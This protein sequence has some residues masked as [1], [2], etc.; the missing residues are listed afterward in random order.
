MGKNCYFATQQIDGVIA[1]ELNCTAREVANL[2]SLLDDY[3]EEAK[4]KPFL[5][6]YEDKDVPAEVLSDLAQTLKAFKQVL[7][8]KAE[9]AISYASTHL[10]STFTATAVAL[11]SAKQFDLADTIAWQ[12]SKVVHALS[13]KT[14]YSIEE[15]C[16]GVTDKSGNPMFGERQIFRKIYKDILA[17]YQKADPESDTYQ[18]L[19]NILNHWGALCMH[20]RCII[21]DT[22]RI[23]LGVYK[24]YAKDINSEEMTEELDDMFNNG[25][26]DPETVTKESWQEEKDKISSF[27]RLSDK[28]KSV[29]S[30]FVYL[31]YEMGVVKTKEGLP[32][33]VVNRVDIK[34]GALGHPSRI[35]VQDTH[36]IIET[37]VRRCPDSKTMFKV[38]EDSAKG[39]IANYSDP[40]HQNSLTLQDWV[41]YQLYAY[42]TG[43][44]ELSLGVAPASPNPQFKTSLFSNYHTGFTLHTGLSRLKSKI[45][46]F[47]GYFYHRVN[48]NAG[49]STAEA[50]L[51]YAIR[52]SYSSILFDQNGKMNPKCFQADTEESKFILSILSDFKYK[53][54][55]SIDDHSILTSGTTYFSSVIYKGLGFDVTYTPTAEEI[56]YAYTQ[57]YNALN[58]I[59]IKDISVSTIVKLHKSNLLTKKMLGAIYDI[60]SSLQS[61]TNILTA[62]KSTSE[63][64]KSKLGRNILSLADMV[65]DAMTSLVYEARARVTDKNGNKTTVSSN[66]APCF[67]TDTVDPLIYYYNA[68]QITEA[69]KFLFDKY[70]YSE[71]FYTGTATSREE[72]NNIQAEDI[73]NYWLRHVWECLEGKNNFLATFSHSRLA[74]MQVNKEDIRM[75]NLFEKDVTIALAQLFWQQVDK[76]D[77]AMATYPLFILGDSGVFRIMDGPVFDT[78]D[79]PAMWTQAINNEIKILGMYAGANEFLESHGYEK[80]HGT[81][82]LWQTSVIAPFLRA[83]EASSEFQ[84]RPNKDTTLLEWTSSALYRS[85]F[86][87]KYIIPVLDEQVKSFKESFDNL[88]LSEMINVE[89]KGTTK[90]AFSHIDSIS[91]VV[92]SDPDAKATL[93]A[94]L[95]KKIRSFVYNYGLHMADQMHMMTVST[96]LYKSLEELQKRYKEVHASGSALDIYAIDPTTKRP[97]F[98]TVNEKGETVLSPYETALYFKDI[99]TNIEE[100][101]PEFAEVVH[102]VLEDSPGQY[103]KYLKNSLTDGQSFRSLES[104]R[105]ISIAQDIWSD[106]E[107]QFYQLLSK[108][109]K[110]PGYNGVLTKEQMKQLDDIGV[111]FQP[112]KPYLFCH[113]MFSYTDAK[114]NQ[115]SVPIAVQ[116]K[117]AEIILIPEFLAEGSNLRHLATAMTKKGIDIA[118]STEVVKVGCFGECDIAFKTGTNKLY[119]DSNGVT[120]GNATTREEQMELED[121]AEQRVAISTLEDMEIALGNAYLHKLDLTTY[122]RQSNVPLHINNPNSI[123]TQMYKIFFTAI[124]MEEDAD[125]SGYLPEG[126]TEIAVGNGHTISLDPSTKHSGQN[127]C[128][129]YNMLIAAS[130]IQGFEEL[131][132]DMQSHEDLSKILSQMSINSSRDTVYNLMNYA[133]ALE[134]EE[135]EE[136]AAEAFLVPLFDSSI[137]KETQANLISLFRKKVNKLMMLGG[138]AVQ[139]SAF[140]IT[141]KVEDSRNPDDGGLKF[142]CEYVKDRAGNFV[143]DEKGKKIKNVLYA[144]CELPWDLFYTDM[145]GNRVELDYDEYC[146]ED[147]S[148]KL[149]ENGKIKLDVDFPGMR[150]LVAY[151]I[152]TERAYSALNLKVVR[153]SRK[154]NGGVIKVPS[155]GTTIAGFDFDIDKLY[156]LRKEFVYQKRKMSDEEVEQVWEALFEEHGDIAMA[157]EIERLK[158]RGQKF[159]HKGKEVIIDEELPRNQLRGFIK[160]TDFGFDEKTTLQDLFN[161]KAIELGLSTKLK[162][163]DY[164][165]SALQNSKVAR[166]NELL[167]LTQLRLRDVETLDARLTPGGFDGA[168]GASKQHRIL[169]SKEALGKL[170]GLSDTE[171]MSTLSELADDKSKDYKSSTDLINPITFIQYNQQNQVAGK[172]IGVFAN[173]NNNHIYSAMLKGLELPEGLSISFGSMA[174]K[175]VSSLLAYNKKSRNKIDIAVAEFLAASVDA[176][177]DPVLNDLNLNSVTA[178]AGAVLARLGYSALE[179]GALFNQPIIKEI[180]AV[181]FNDHIS[182]IDTAI[183]IACENLFTSEMPAMAKEDLTTAN[184]LKSIASYN[185]V[186]KEQGAISWIKSSNV[187]LMQQKAIVEL[188]KDALKAG[189]AVGV[190][191]RSTKYTAASSVPSSLGHMHNMF[192]QTQ[193]YEE[194]NPSEKVKITGWDGESIQAMSP[195]ASKEAAACFSKGSF[196]SYLYEISHSPFAF[197]QCMYDMMGLFVTKICAKHFPYETSAYKRTRDLMNQMTKSTTLSGETVNSIHEEFTLYTLSKLEGSIFNGNTVIDKTDAE[198]NPITISAHE[199]YT[200]IVPKKVA[201]WQRTFNAKANDE[202]FE[203]L[204]AGYIKEVE[205]I[206][207]Y[208]HLLHKLQ[209]LEYENEEGEI[210]TYISLNNAFSNNTVDKMRMMQAWTQLALTSEDAE[211]AVDLFMYC[212]Y[213]TGLAPSP[214][215]FIH[216]ATPFVK[217]LVP[218]DDSRNFLQFERDLLD[219]HKAIGTTA[220]INNFINLYIRNNSDDWQFVYAPRSRKEIGVFNSLTTEIREDGT[221]VVKDEIE[222]NLD[223]NTSNITS[224]FSRII[225]EIQ[226][227][228]IGSPEIA[229]YIPAIKI[230]KSIYYLSAK[231][232]DDGRPFNVRPFSPTVTYV[233]QSILGQNNGFKNYY[234]STKA[235]PIEEEEQAEGGKAEENTDPSNITSEA[236]H[237]AALNYTNRLTTAIED[238]TGYSLNEALEQSPEFFARE[239]MVTKDEKDNDIISCF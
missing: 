196:E 201:A 44:D 55:A 49:F 1:A 92:T 155:A 41:A 47:G 31:H 194:T 103:S 120:I 69:K 27:A 3:R 147:G 28:V 225:L 182:D 80:I 50:K 51:R 187:N 109:R 206:E 211:M 36:T 73:S 185:A 150:D 236:L 4:Q 62:I 13:K 61:N 116:H 11:D 52:N 202:I 86:V 160:L 38:I 63:G 181:Y 87:E 94:E 208:N 175:D 227:G 153:F 124:N 105:K 37:M 138:S 237:Q 65:N 203:A 216:F 141:K 93:N 170:K 179:I 239:H 75:E 112:R 171:F 233:R 99:L 102:D 165:K 22:E 58:E 210:K 17:A 115:R 222:I 118:C 45:L 217:Q 25:L 146:N 35:P 53:E 14:G 190:Y 125:Y 67:F 142:V 79:I 60:Y 19:R 130:I 21:R 70:L 209:V 48:L 98:E 177:K 154:E 169:R 64:E 46:G 231:E 214:K 168:R 131:V 76:T 104:Y 219:K 144:E 176:V 42:I 184:L 18:D 34:R 173:Q 26:L 30:N 157:L 12:F 91:A 40:K 229:K 178:T 192:Y 235:A 204:D 5:A 16:R 193:K 71:A 134:H 218:A 74:E 238:V 149:T 89:R 119:V 128:T 77:G 212:V 29:L 6:E 108:F 113:E 139:A 148:L 72:V 56:N 221:K 24:E 15:I 43:K 84:N 23:Y 205:E 230:G 186:S 121:F 59:G 85:D 224:Y 7:D 66:Q 143:L 9:E 174:G 161:Q 145:S 200:Q 195:A 101:D 162:E 82:K 39:F 97:I 106:K 215:S 199:Y 133:V 159:V 129:H 151:R 122:Y 100:T 96:G 78:E 207:G 191:L 140:G 107:E 10:A 127:L 81:E 132:A 68:G 180:C 197:E 110:A 166:N 172:S 114:G 136:E 135:G 198:G 33:S 167:R 152:P 220:E 126:V 20:S 57:I 2:R 226:S 228:G 232:V 189:K 8:Q 117:C 158:R 137:S 111:V 163:Y 32:I 54:T 156:L 88:G 123:G 188:F 234:D 183:N 223:A 164:S 90:A 83:I 213:N 95:D